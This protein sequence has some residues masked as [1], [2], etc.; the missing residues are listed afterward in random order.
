VEGE[1]SNLSRPSS[2]HWYFSLKD[3]QSQVRCAYFRFKNTHTMFTPENGLLI[4]VQAKVSLYPERGDYQLIVERMEAAGDGL[5]RI[6]FDQLVKKL[7]DVGLFNEARKRALPKIPGHIGVITSPTGAAIQ[8][9]L[10]VLGR[11]FPFAAITI[12]PTKVQGNEA[13]DEI[14]RAIQTANQ[15]KQAEVLILARGGGSLEDLWPFNEERVAYAIFNSD[16]PIVSGVGHETD[17]TIAD[18]VADKRAPTPSAA[19]ELISPNQLTLTQ[20]CDHVLR[21]LEAYMMRRL[22][23]YAQKIDWL[24]KRLRHPGQHL[25]HQQ[26]K[27]HRLEKQLFNSMQSVL[28][29]RTQ[30]WLAISKQLHTLSPLA[31]LDRGFAIVTQA[32]PPHAVLRSIH[33]IAPQAL[34]TLRFSDGSVTCQVS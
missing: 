10:S 2:G 6:A 16:L 25:K 21:Q 12:Y 31:T 5:L 9:I 29:Q 22:E 23:H 20:T 11:R 33:E 28:K 1:I 30:H 15:H 8:D 17:T 3:A 14:V 18:F 24:I 7:T 34:L 27:L 26:E 4:R 19:A 32:T 13:A